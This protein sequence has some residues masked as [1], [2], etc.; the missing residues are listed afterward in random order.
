M[1]ADPR[2]LLAKPGLAAGALEGI[3]PA[4]A[5]APTSTFQVASP[6]A[7]M[8]A[9][10]DESA[11]AVSQLLFG[12]LLEVLEFR[13]GFAFGQSRRDGYVG[14]VRREALAE[15]VIGPTH[16]L[17]A[18]SAFAFAEPRVRAPPFGPL[19]LNALL[20]VEA[21]EG[22]FVRIARAG[23]ISKRAIRPIGAPLVDPVR[24]AAL[25]MGAPYLWAGRSAEGLDCSGLVQQALLA[26]GAASPRDADQQA[27]LGREVERSDLRRGDLV[28]WR[29]HIGFVAGAGDQLLHANAHHMAVAR[30][31][32]AGALSR[33][34]AAG[35]GDPLAFRRLS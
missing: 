18:R 32:L 9:A 26:C 16:F 10:A 14:H 12:E 6:A 5:Y 24:A 25:M 34:A 22:A 4:R 28:V 7:W 1:S 33:I 17:A 2:L 30:E 19:S 23:W 11:P 8:R 20:A 27:L 29:G 31:R 35:G 21:E 13:E 3:E 15:E